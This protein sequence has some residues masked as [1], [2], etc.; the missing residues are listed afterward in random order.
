M[1]EFKQC[2]YICTYIIKHR[3]ELFSFHLCN[4]LGK[5]TEAKRKLIARE[6]ERER[7]RESG[8]VFF[9]RKDVERGEIDDVGLVK[10][11]DQF[12]YVAL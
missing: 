6:R 12:D 9:G 4:F 8:S 1:R 7:E 3:N 11:I 10:I 2:I 5:Q